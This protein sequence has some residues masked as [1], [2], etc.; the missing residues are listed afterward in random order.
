MVHNRLAV[1]VR[2][3]TLFD[4]GRTRPNSRTARKSAARRGGTSYWTVTRTG[5]PR[6]S[7]PPTTGGSQ[8]FHGVRSRPI[9]SGRRRN[10]ARTIE[11]MAPPPAYTNAVSI[12]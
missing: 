8:G 3:Q 6:P 7:S 4:T 1:N 10:T 12:L 2:A 9:V 5:P 11:R